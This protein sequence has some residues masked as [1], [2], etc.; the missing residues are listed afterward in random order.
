MTGTRDITLEEL[1]SRRSADTYTLACNFE[2]EEAQV[3]DIN[4]YEPFVSMNAVPSA[5]GA[6][7]EAM[8]IYPETL[9][10]SRVL[11]IGY[12]R[13]GKLIAD[14]MKGFGAKVSVTA[15]NHKDILFARANSLDFISYDKLDT[16]LSGFD[17]IFQTVPQLI[18]D[19]V[20]IDKINGIIIE[21]ASKGAGSDISYAESI[22]KNIVYAPALPERYSPISAGKILYDSIKSILKDKSISI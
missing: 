8:K 16:S 13:I 11:V 17:I 1:L 6:I 22:G 20:R 3:F 14:R 10:E 12:G 7:F 21:L 5:E 9:F 2:D 18:L 4:K 15:R 19:K